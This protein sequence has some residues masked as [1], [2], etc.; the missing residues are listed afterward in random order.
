M[1][2]EYLQSLSGVEIPELDHVRLVEIPAASA[3]K[4]FA[5]RGERDRGNAPAVGVH[6]ADGLAGGQTDDLNFSA[7]AQQGE[8]LIIRGKEDAADAEGPQLDLADRLPGRSIAEEQTR[9]LLGHDHGE[10]LAVQGKDD[11]AERLR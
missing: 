1:P 8:G 4:D 10:R 5:V 7:L 3:R 9:L 11:R 6:F 2:V